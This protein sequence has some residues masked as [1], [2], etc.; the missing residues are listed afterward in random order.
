MRHTYKILET[1][2]Q[3][4]INLAHV[5]RYLRITHT[6][7]DELLS[8]FLATA[9][10]AAEHYIRSHIVSKK[11]QL[12]IHDFSGD[13]I[14]LYVRVMH[15]V[16]ALQIDDQ[17]LDIAT[18][19]LCDEQIILPKYY[20]GSLELTYEVGYSVY[21][22][23]PAGLVQGILRHCAELYDREGVLLGIPEECISL[24]TPYRLPSL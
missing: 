11:I 24:Y 7:D 4:I 5:K 15:R 14:D 22:S 23:V 17:K 1:A 3:E 9:I 12:K 21:D 19:E 16:L 6:H 2:S 20:S 8:I 10:E 18:L 13:V